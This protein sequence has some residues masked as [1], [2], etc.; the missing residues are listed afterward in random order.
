MA[1]KSV[2]FQ[3]NFHGTEST[4]EAYWNGKLYGHTAYVRVQRVGAPGKAGVSN[5]KLDLTPGS[6]TFARGSMQEAIAQAFGWTE[7][8]ER[9]PEPEPVAV[10]TM[11]EMP[12]AQSA[13]QSNAVAMHVN[14]G[15]EIVNGVNMSR[16]LV[17]RTVYG[18]QPVY[19][20][21]FPDGDWA[22]Q[23]HN[24]DWPG[25]FDWHYG[26]GGHML[27]W[28]TEEQAVSAAHAMIRRSASGH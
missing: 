21:R 10:G 4:Q 26:I 28:Q 1:G 14:T 17:G 2:R 8:V 20:V 11:P 9:D 27:V 7:F 18:D 16:K 19:V 22:I 6:G 15:R 13:S 3:F 24:P 5:E 23:I 12:A 25:Q